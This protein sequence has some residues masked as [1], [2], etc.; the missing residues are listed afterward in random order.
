MTSHVTTRY[1]H[2]AMTLHWL[3]AIGVIAQ[4]VLG[5]WMI[6]IPKAPAGVRAY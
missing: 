3:V 4:I 5:L 1:D 6:E 2:V